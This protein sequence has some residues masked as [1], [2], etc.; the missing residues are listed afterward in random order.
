VPGCTGCQSGG[1]YIKLQLP[2]VRFYLVINIAVCLSACGGGGGGGSDDDDADSGPDVF[3]GF[4]VDDAVQGL[5]VESAGGAVQ[6]TDE[7]GVFSFVPNDPLTFKID[8]VVIGSVP[9]GLEVITPGNFGITT[10]PQV[11]RF[12]Q[13]MDTSPGTP[14]IDLRGL[15]LPNSP[16][17]F[18]QSDSEFENDPAVMNA[19]FEST[20]AGASGVLI[21]YA[22]AR[23]RFLAGS[24]RVIALA[25]FEN[26]VAYPVTVPLP[27]EPCL[28]FF[29][30]DLSGESV[31]RD[32]I[33]AD[34]ADAAESFTWMID[35]ALLVADIDPD[36]R[37]T[38]T[39]NG[40]TGN[41]IHATVATECLTCN[42][43]L[44][45]VIEI[46][47]QTFYT[48]IP[49]STVDFSGQVLN[50]SGD[51]GATTATFSAAGTVVFDDGSSMQAANW[52]V[53]TVS[54]VLLLG[55]TGA[56]GTSGLMFAKAILI[57]GTVG[58]GKFVFL[59]ASVD[60]TDNDGVASQAEFDTNG[61]YDDVEVQV[62]TP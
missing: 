46:E 59:N 35:S 51:G 4:F 8:D 34:P 50:L 9:S 55:G 60:D 40:T 6:R 56:S 47:R 19:L 32:D 41:R 1:F 17:D 25:D 3:Y 13:S 5:I 30:A 7:N 57:E 61:I 27:G 21:P 12:I 42:P 18:N 24:N 15:D 23:T 49:I 43:N 38:V 10:G 44:G 16:I 58:D 48:A 14:G 11:F 2:S 20:F 37:V 33:A 54:N 26:L 28:V 62:S 29:N 53:D 39:K 31:C 36:T 52:S 45:P 22:T